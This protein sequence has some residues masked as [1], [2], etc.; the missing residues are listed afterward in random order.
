MKAPVI[1][2]F[3]FALGLG[4]A[5]NASFAQPSLQALQP[6]DQE[7]A[8]VLDIAR[9]VAEQALG[10]PVKLQVDTIDRHGDWVFLLSQMRAG[11]GGRLDLS[12]TAYAEQQAAG[13][14]SDVFAV[15]L[16]RDGETW[17]VVAK[18]VGPGDVA[19]ETWPQEYGAPGA[20]FGQ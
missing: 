3:A 9:P 20:L 10:L 17:K 2:R 6:D 19:W 16:K 11:D 4:L 18:A 1:L 5:M 15:L 13:S 12:G 7:Y 14:M 8:E